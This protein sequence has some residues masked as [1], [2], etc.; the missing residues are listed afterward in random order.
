MSHSLQQ[1]T[2]LLVDDDPVARLLTASVLEQHGFLVLQAGSGRERRGKRPV[3]VTSQRCQCGWRR[4]L[5]RSSR[6]YR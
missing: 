5:E 2:I 3:S 1:D 6:K 4:D